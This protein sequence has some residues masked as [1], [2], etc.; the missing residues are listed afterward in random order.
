[1][2]KTKVAKKLD[3]FE[4]EVVKKEREEKKQQTEK[5]QQRRQASK[6]KEGHPEVWKEATKHPKIPDTPKL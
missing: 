2:R 4:K 3:E 6:E 5:V 1:M